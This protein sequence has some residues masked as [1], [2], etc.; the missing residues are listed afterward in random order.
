MV[1]V[2]KN[3]PLNAGDIRDSGSNPVLGRA[4]DRGHGNPLQCSCLENPVDRRAWWATVRRV[5][6][7]QTQLNNLAR[8]HAHIVLYFRGGTLKKM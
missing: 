5:T 2:V 7:C 8:T 1:L 4:P 3:S 6:K